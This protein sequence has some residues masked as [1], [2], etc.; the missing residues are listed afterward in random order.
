MTQGFTQGFVEWLADSSGFPTHVAAAG[1][2]LLPGCAYVAP[3]DFHMGVNR[4]HRIVLTKDDRENGMRPAV[5]CLFRSVEAVFK[6]NAVGILLTGMG[7]DGVDELKR[8]REAGAVTIAQDEETSVVHGMPGQ[9]IK[10]GAATHILSP[11][12]IAKLLGTIVT[13]A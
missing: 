13:K 2:S 1:E 4:G 7:Q 3:D 5:S 6:Q 10:V 8:L 12:N 11:E 9:A